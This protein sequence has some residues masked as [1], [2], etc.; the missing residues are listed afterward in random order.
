MSKDIIRW[1]KKNYSA[2]PWK[3]V[4]VVICTLHAIPAAGVTGC[5]QLTGQQNKILTLQI[6]FTVGCFYKIDLST[7]IYIV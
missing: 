6:L 5:M 1:T 4:T 2:N 7:K 3:K